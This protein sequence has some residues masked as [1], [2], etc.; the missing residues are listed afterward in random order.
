M[1]VRVL[2]VG[3]LKEPYLRAAE[4]E[5][6]RRLAHYCHLDI[7]EYADDAA[8]LAAVPAGARLYALDE[9]GDNLSSLELARDL[10]AREENA[11]GSAPLLFA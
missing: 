7:S 10:M 1:K 2:A 6:A 3:K 5:Y 8:L 9:R 4:D 11:G